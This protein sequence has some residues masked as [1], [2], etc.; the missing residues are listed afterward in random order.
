MSIDEIFLSIGELGKRQC[1]LSFLLCLLNGYAAFHMLQY[2]FISF[3]VDF[4]CSD[5]SRSNVSNSCPGDD[6]AQ[7][8]DIIF[9]TRHKSSI[10]SEWSLVCDQSSRV[11]M[12][13]SA[14]MFGVMIGAFVLG[15][16]ADN[17]GR[18]TCLMVTTLGVLV[19]NTLAA[20]VSSYKLYI[21]TK[22]V[23]GFF[24]AGFILASFVLINEIVGASKR[25][26]MGLAFQSSFSINIVLMS[27]IAYQIPHWRQLTLAIS[28]LGAPLLV[29]I[30]ITP[31]SPRWLLSKNKKKEALKVL[32]DI[33]AGNGT[34]MTDKMKMMLDNDE[35]KTDDDNKV[36]EGL[37]D[38]FR[39]RQLAAV[40]MIQ[41]FS[42]FV[43][44]GSYYALTIAAGAAGSADLY[45]GT[46]LSGAVEIPAYILAYWLLR[47]AGRR[48][49]PFYRTQQFEGC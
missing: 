9:D 2:P 4:S 1:I 34:E 25:S 44:S 13:M 22:L 6:S 8:V 33:A 42:W 43:N 21:I 39:T 32:S 18:K 27:F 46:A 45:T 17:Y 11:K 31:E 47:V 40:T 23:V 5:Q 14:F 49:G 24:Q 3:S 29:I 10:V 16:F 15:T 20:S 41:I 30:M 35:E 28:A 12:T 37:T 36:V 19:F 48:Q 38:L 7:C 26:L